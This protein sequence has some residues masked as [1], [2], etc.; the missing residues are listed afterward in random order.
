[1]A[2]TS[3]KSRHINSISC[4]I[5]CYETPHEQ[6]EKLLGSLRIAIH[7]LRASQE[8]TSV[9]VYLIDNSRKSTLS[10]IL[11]KNQQEL[12][13]KDN[14][15][16]HFVGGHGNVGYGAAQNMVI[17]SI[18]S[19]LHLILNP[20][21][22]IKEDALVEGVKVFVNN[23]S[24]VMLSPDA[25]NGLGEKQCLCKRLPT[26]LTLIVRGFLP[27]LFQKIFKS[28]LDYYEM[29]D[30]SETEITEGI[31]LI[32]GCFMLADTKVLQEVGGFDER[33][34]LYF[35]DFDLSL[36]IGTQGSLVH[37][38]NVRI[39]HEGG[40]TAKKGVT[41]IWYFIKSGIRFF[42]KHGWRYW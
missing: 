7:K 35:E 14:I 12:M 28:R 5:V 30:L 8:S 26:I 32:S 1:M 37:S 13:K 15:Q 18:D 19:D 2:T 40:N 38:P 42:N 22:T 16:F 6:I 27:K 39:T 34:F 3:S 41:H 25:K 11:L 31:P 17:R 20:D 33:Y 4:G 24:V 29:H 9:A 10:L 36:R 23:R 21:V